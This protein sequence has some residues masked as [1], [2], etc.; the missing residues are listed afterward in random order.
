MMDPE[1]CFLTEKIYRGIDLINQGEFFAAHEVLEQAWIQESQPVRQFY[2]GLIQISVLLYHLERN[3]RKGAAKLLSMAI[4]NLIPFGEITRPVNVN[5]LL[6]DL[7]SIQ[8]RVIL[9]DIT[10]HPR[11]HIS[12]QVE[13]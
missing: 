4:Q 9:S 1:N 5:R 8:K 13:K 12:I 10:I 3:N 2:Q 7:R 6:E 11:V